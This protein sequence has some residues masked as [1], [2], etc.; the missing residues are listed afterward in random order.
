MR[1]CVHGELHRGNNASILFYRDRKV[2]YNCYSS[3]CVDQEPYLLGTR[4]TT[5]LNSMDEMTE[6]SVAQ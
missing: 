4:Q 2:I 3:K 5:L 1:I 6:T